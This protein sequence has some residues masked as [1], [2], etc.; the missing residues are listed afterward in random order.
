MAYIQKLDKTTMT[1]QQMADEL[2]QGGYQ[3][4]KGNQFHS[5]TVWRMY[6]KIVAP[7][8]GSFSEV[9]PIR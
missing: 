1:Y 5:K 7:Q 8:N 6:Q 3:T 4:S 9:H 2:N